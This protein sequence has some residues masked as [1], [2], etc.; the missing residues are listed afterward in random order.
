MHKKTIIIDL[1]NVL[2]DC[3][4]L[5]RL[6]E[7]LGKS[8]VEEDFKDFYKQDIIKD[9]QEKQRF[10]D[11]LFSTYFYKDVPIKD[12]VHKVLKELNK[13]F[14]V[15]LCSDFLWPNHEW[16]CDKLISDKYALFR[17][18]FSYLH[19][20]QFMFLRAKQYFN[21][22]VQIDDRIS[23]LSPYAKER[24]LFTT[25]QNQ[26]IPD[27]ELKKQNITR[28]NNWKEITERL[29]GGIPVE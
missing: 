26:N 11:F 16:K 7:F 14:E 22:D 24:L 19:P 3:A 21:V 5:A 15:Y 27:E 17:K 9:P 28:V 23:Y 29:L 6:N 20:S 25:F 10:F 8:Y 13:R 2:V 4:M 18:E 1:D 12:D